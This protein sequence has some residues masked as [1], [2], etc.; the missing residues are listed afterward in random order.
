MELNIEYYN[1]KLIVITNA[2]ASR[3]VEEALENEEENINRKHR[4]VLIYKKTPII[5]GS[6]VSG[7]RI[8]DIFSQE[9][10]RDRIEELYEE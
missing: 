7:R 2:K 6:M 8:M 1:P 4:D 5:L 10:L 9:R 3:L